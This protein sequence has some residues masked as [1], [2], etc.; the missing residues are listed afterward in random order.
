VV[1]AQGMGAL[2]TKKYL[3][4][5]ANFSKKA[6]DKNS[7]NIKNYYVQKCKISISV[8]DSESCKPN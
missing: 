8:T 1:I 5:Q 3:Y 6:D 4:Q 7:L 2:T